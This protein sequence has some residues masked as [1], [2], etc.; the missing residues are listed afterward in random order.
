MRNQQA[1][2]VASP[3]VS[4]G[5][6]QAFLKHANPSQGVTES[7][8]D[9]AFSAFGTV[10]KVE[11]DKKKGFAYLDFADSNGLQKAIVAS[12]VK[13]A[14]GQVVVLER[15]TGTS[16]QNRNAR[17][18]GTSA[19]GRGGIIPNTRGGRGSGGRGRGGKATAS[20]AKAGSSNVPASPET[21]PSSQS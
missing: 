9:E 7:L 18:G 8:L 21:V 10:T 2:D 12:P 6:T 16:L 11:I 14:Q 13:I 3:T 17:G 19:V 20:T 5:A 1:T 15:K 4:P